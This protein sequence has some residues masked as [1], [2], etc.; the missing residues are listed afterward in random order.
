MK[1]CLIRSSL[2]GL[3]TSKVLVLRGGGGL[4]LC[5]CLC[6]SL[7][8]PKQSGYIYWAQRKTGISNHSQVALGFSNINILQRHNYKTLESIY[9]QQLTQG[10]TYTQ[11]FTLKTS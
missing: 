2:G 5:L 8:C 6:A 3:L 10:Y 4:M 7:W 1:T 11:L 9:N